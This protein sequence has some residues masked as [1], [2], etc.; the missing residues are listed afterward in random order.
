M[1]KENLKMFLDR[2]VKNRTGRAA[3]K[4]FAVNPGSDLALAPELLFVVPTGVDEAVG[5]VGITLNQGCKRVIAEQQRLVQIVRYNNRLAAPL[6]AVGGLPFRKYRVG[7]THTLSVDVS[8]E[9]PL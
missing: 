2:E 9:Q 7:H 4:H 8:P 6:R 1:S 5:P 3:D